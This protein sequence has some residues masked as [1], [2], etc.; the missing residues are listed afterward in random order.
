M[1]SPAA[2]RS[3]TTPEEIHGIFT[4]LL[5]AGDLDGLLTLYDPDA[6]LVAGPD[7]LATGHAQ[8]REGLAPFVAMQA[9]IAF[10][11]QTVI[12]AG[13]V[14]L[15]HAHW[16]G[17]GTTPEGQIESGGVTSEV[18]RRQPDGTWKYLIDDPG[19]GVATP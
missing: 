10:G 5:E 3:A 17:T 2:P 4:E 15:V 8:I 9:K 11:T 14:A 7:H 1:A 12:Y 18:T 16:S 13:D 19:F 6:V